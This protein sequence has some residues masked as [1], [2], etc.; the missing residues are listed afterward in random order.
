MVHRF[1]WSRV[2]N[3]PNNTPPFPLQV[4]DIGEVGGKALSEALKIN[5]TLTV[6]NLKRDNQRELTKRYHSKPHIFHGKLYSQKTRLV[7]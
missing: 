4:N 2:H 7:P 1:Y 6:L 3:Q 5:T